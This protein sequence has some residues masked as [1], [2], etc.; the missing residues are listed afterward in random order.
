M[1]QNLLA[2]QLNIS[3]QPITGPLGDDM[4]SVGDV[5]SKIS[6]F[7]IPVAAVILVFI[8]MWGGYDFISSQGAPEKL[9]AGKAKMTA[10]LVGFIL[11]ILSYT[12]TNLL[13]KI[14]GFSGI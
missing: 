4:N 10:G 12:I 5:V 6:T 13:A 11:L 14:F 1:K 7:L 8:L 2:Q 9:K 3:G